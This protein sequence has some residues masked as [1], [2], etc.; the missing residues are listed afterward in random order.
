MEGGPPEFPRGSTCPA[1][2]RSV[3]EEVLP[4]S[5]T[6][7]SPSLARRSRA[8]RLTTRFVTSRPVLRPIRQRP[9]TPPV[10]RRR[11]ITHRRFRLFPVRSPLLGESRLIS[12]LQGTKMFQFPCL[13][14]RT[15]GFSTGWLGMT[16]AGFPH[17]G[18]P[19]SKPARRLPEAIAADSALHRLLAPGHPPCALSSLKRTNH[20]S[21]CIELA[22]SHALLGTMRTTNLLF[23]CQGSQPKAPE[24]QY[25]LRGSGTSTFITAS[26]KGGDEDIRGAPGRLL[27]DPAELPTASGTAA[28]DFSLERR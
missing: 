19:G 8:V 15:Y 2:L 20:R 14:S 25:A 26:G 13:P 12:T 16:P 24:T 27:A 17:S 5:P 22:R 7:L 11:A 1:V 10:Q 18:T 4:L 6:G 21:S 23:A 9:M 3:A 28:S